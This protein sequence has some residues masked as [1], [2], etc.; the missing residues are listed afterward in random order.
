ML[1][2]ARRERSIEIFQ[3]TQ[4]VPAE[5]CVAGKGPASHICWYMQQS[6]QLRYPSYYSRSTSRTTAAAAP[7][8]AL[9]EPH[10]TQTACTATIPKHTCAHLFQCTRQS[11]QH[12]PVDAASP[13]G[14]GGRVRHVD[15]LAHNKIWRVA[16]P[17]RLTAD[18]QGCCQPLLQHL[19]CM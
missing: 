17:T 1:V 5:V 7:A 10:N 4:L 18:G 16:L 9:F 8:I 12:V 15:A 3:H 6:Q 14:Q 19:P 2:T 11:L 13:R